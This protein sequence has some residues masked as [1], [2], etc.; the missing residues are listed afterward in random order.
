M[1]KFS[2]IFFLFSLSIFSVTAQKNTV[3]FHCGFAGAPSTEV[4]SMEELLKINDVESIRKGLVSPT[5]SIRFLSVI[6]LERLEKRGLIE[7]TKKDKIEILNNYSNEYPVNVCNGCLGD[8]FIK[9]SKLLADKKG[10]S[11]RKQ[12]EEWA[13]NVIEKSNL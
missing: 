1:K 13:D 9:L 2:L 3:G 12:A 5:S 4:V 10:L 8:D 11:F 7:F 6:I